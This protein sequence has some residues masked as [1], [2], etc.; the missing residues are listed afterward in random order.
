MSATVSPILDEHLEEVG[1]FLHEQMGRRIPTAQWVASLR[2]DWAAQT[3]NHGMQL[4]DGDRLVG[5]LL[6]VYSDQWVGDRVERFCNPHSWCVL[7][8]YRSGSLPLVLAVIRQPGY[9]FTMYTPNPKVAEVFQGLR[10]RVLDDALLHI[11]HLPRMASGPPEAFVEFEPE[12]VSDRLSGVAREVYEAHRNIPW[13]HFA[14]Y[15][16]PGDAHLAVYKRDRWKRLPCAR[17][18]YP[19]GPQAYARYGAMLRSALL[20]RRGL[21]VTR[22]E[23]RFLADVPPL[24]WRSRRLQPKLVS[25]RSLA[26]GQALDLYSELVALDL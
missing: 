23:G 19:G 15:G 1:A 17:L 7:E 20:F 14:A 9:H 6:A 3:P 4:R 8:G 11:P 26:D 18:L 21:A 25:S 2:H 16:T 12:R 5:V 13:L 22:V 10:F 24:T